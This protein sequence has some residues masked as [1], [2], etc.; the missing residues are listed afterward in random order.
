MRRSQKWGLFLA[1]TL[2]FGGCHNR[3]LKRPVPA[4]SS[5]WVQWGGPVRS[6]LALESEPDFSDLTEL[7]VLKMQSSPGKAILTRDGVAVLPTL[8]GRLWAF[9]LPRGKKLGEY[10]LPAK[11]PGTAL[12][13]KDDV[14]VAQRF[15][16]KT[17]FLFSP[18]T[19]KKR[20]KV[21]LGDIETEPLLAGDTL[22]VTTLFQGVAAVQADSGKLLWKKALNAQS[23]SSPVLRGGRLFFG[24]DKGRLFALNRETGD[25]LF[26]VSLGG[27]VR[28]AP[29][30]RDGRIFIGTTEG[31]FL[32]LSAQT[33]EILWEKR[34]PAEIVHA[35]ALTHRAVFLVANDG[36]LYKFSAKN[37]SLFWKQN[38]NGVAGTAPLLLGNRLVLGTLEHTLLVVDAQSGRI[39]FQKR[40]KGR[41]RTLPVPWKNDLLVASENRWFYIFRRKGSEP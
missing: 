14:L 23:H 5:D 8:A 22:F 19:G 39:L 13:Y 1:L 7:K 40:L 30:C 37:G 10:K 41:I 18:K 9:A 31:R 34:L 4:G 28:A 27:I 38:L 21:K 26:A 29:T 24:D 33:G 12:L 32:A 25:S 2:I 20:W 3:L 35:A 6:T 16:K 17:L 11:I 15:G 36:F